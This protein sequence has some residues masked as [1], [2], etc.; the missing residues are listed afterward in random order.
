MSC[1]VAPLKF[2]RLLKKNVCLKIY[3]FLSSS[4]QKNKRL[5]QSPT[6]TVLQLKEMDT[7]NEKAIK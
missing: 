1:A 2:Y 7:R 6:L 5:S 3:Y 4:L